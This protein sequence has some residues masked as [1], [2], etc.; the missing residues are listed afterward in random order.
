MHIAAAIRNEAVG[1]VRPPVS[2]LHNLCFIFARLAIVA[3]MIALITTSVVVSNA[4]TCVRG[5]YR[6]NL[7]IIDL[8]ASAG[9]TYVVHL[10]IYHVPTKIEPASHSEH[11][12][13]SSIPPAIPSGSHLEIP[14]VP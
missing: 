6:C 4:S 1:L 13:Q 12:S 14:S 8:S 9:A 7:E 2:K 5:S 11:F 3:W 10:L